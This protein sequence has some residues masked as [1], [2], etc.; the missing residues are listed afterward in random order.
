MA[1]NTVRGRFVWHELMTPDTSGAH[2]FVFRRWS[3]G[4]RSR[5]N[6]IPPT[7]CLRPAA[8]RWAVRSRPRVRRIGCTTSARRTSTRRLQRSRAAAAACRRKSPPCRAAAATPCWPSAQGA[9][10]GVY[11]HPMDTARNPRRSVA[12]SP[13]TS[14]RPATGAQPSILFGGVRLGEAGR[15]RHG[16]DGQVRALRQQRRAARRHV[17]QAG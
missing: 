15:A 16:R 7:R 2:A 9:A 6:T 1:D 5:G 3:A 8:A 13:G 11:Y 4:K 14:W 17:Q 10:F 12:S